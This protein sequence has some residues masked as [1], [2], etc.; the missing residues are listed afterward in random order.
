MDT[1]NLLAEGFESALLPCSLILLI[2]GAAMALTARSAAI[3]AISGF[4][5]GVLGLSW[6]RFA[7]RGGGFHPAV[8]AV[9]MLLAVV[10]LFVPVLRRFD[11]VGLGS[12]LLAGAGA[13]EIWKP[14]VGESFGKLLVELPGRGFSGLALMTVFLAGTLA[15]LIALGAAHHLIP[16][17]VLNRI[18]PYWAVVGAGALVL[19]AAATAAGL[20]DDLVGRLFEWSLNDDRGPVP[21]G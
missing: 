10:V 11:L 16:D 3:P 5:V 7:D 6:L 18:E 8:A 19:L 15:P 9:L 13:A 12:G 1:I 2:P 17:R 20:H 4:G 14:C 21:A